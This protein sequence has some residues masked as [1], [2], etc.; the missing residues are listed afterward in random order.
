MSYKPKTSHLLLPLAF[1]AVLASL[2]FLNCTLGDKHHGKHDADMADHHAGAADH[3]KDDMP[4]HD[5]AQ[6]IVIK[7]GYARS[8]GASAKTGAAFMLIVNYTDADDRLVSVRTNMSQRAELHTH[9]EG[10]NGVMMMR[11][12]EGGF[13]IPAD[14]GLLLGRGGRHVMMMGLTQPLA[15]GDVVTLFLTFETAGEIIVKVPVDLERKASHDH[16]SH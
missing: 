8:N 4:M 12:V 2:A 13:V 7:N 6:G 1:L 14:D 5:E 16:A 9:I 3:H 11:E 15:Q 10:D